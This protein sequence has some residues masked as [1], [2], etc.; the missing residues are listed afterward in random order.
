VGLRAGLELLEKGNIFM[1]SEM[2][3]NNVT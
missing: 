1:I 2:Y 3:E